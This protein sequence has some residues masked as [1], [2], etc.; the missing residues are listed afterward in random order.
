MEPALLAAS[1]AVATLAGGAF[2]ALVMRRLGFSRVLR[3][4]RLPL[5]LWLIAAAADFTATA[6]AAVANPLLE[7]NPY[8][9]YAVAAYGGLGLA[10]F[11]F[12]WVVS[13]LALAML[14]ETCR[15]KMP[16]SAVEYLQL[17]LTYT[18]AAGHLLAWAAWAGYG[19]IADGSPPLYY[20][21][22][23]LLGG[24]LGVIH[25]AARKRPHEPP[26]PNH[27]PA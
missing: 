7:A 1:V 3:L 18:L 9:R 24:G 21:P 14:L 23:V 13:W 26:G 17:A 4:I 15:G 12:L 6:E 8:I 11:A 22:Y 20:F 10:A 16:G 25:Q 5:I 2:S 27:R 19:S